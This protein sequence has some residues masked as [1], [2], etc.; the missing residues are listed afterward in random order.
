[1]AYIR[2]PYPNELYHHGI[3]GQKWGIRRYQNPDGS[4]TP[5]GKKRYLKSGTSN[6]INELVKTGW[7]VDNTDKYYTDMHKTKS[8]F[9][10]EISLS[11]SGKFPGGEKNVTPEEANFAVNRITKNPSQVR[12]NLSKAIVDTYYD[13]YKG[14]SGSLLSKAEFEKGLSFDVMFVGSDHVTAVISPADK[15]TTF[16][17]DLYP[18][19]GKRSGPYY[20][21]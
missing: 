9:K 3:K 8:G 6:A 12:K 2:A 1:M 16:G 19:T 17:I 21:D 13:D 18:R 15:L 14:Y 10:F 7:K 11:N 5:A 4:L 20:L